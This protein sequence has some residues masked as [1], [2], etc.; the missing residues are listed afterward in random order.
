MGMPKGCSS[1]SSVPATAGM[2][3]WRGKGGTRGSTGRARATSRP[4]GGRAQADI[5][6]V[7]RGQTRPTPNIGSGSHLRL[8]I[9]VLLGELSPDPR[10]FQLLF[11]ESHVVGM[12]FDDDGPVEPLKPP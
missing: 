12:R 9:R 2:S 5:P 11:D 6:A 1:A 10:A 4:G 3:G 8:P 7:G